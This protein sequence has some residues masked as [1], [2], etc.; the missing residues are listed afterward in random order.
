MISGLLSL[1]RGLSRFGPDHLKAMTS[2]GV[3][4]VSHSSWKDLV[5]VPK[6][7]IPHIALGIF[8]NGVGS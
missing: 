3:M 5:F 8:L 6:L 4:D 2:I 7:V 1:L